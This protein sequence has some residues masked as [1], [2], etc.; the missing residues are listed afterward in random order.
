MKR[1]HCGTGH[2]DSLP[3]CEVTDLFRFSQIVLPSADNSECMQNRTRSF[4]PS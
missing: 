2:L 4:P 3:R 1:V